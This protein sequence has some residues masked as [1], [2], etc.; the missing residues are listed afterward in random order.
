VT[1]G[2]RHV[3]AESR[4]AINPRLLVAAVIHSGVVWTQWGNWSRVAALGAVFLV[5]AVA[6]QVLARLSGRETPRVAFAKFLTNA[7]LVLLAGHLSAW[8]F[9]AYLYLTFHALA[10]DT[11]DFRA[12]RV[13]CVAILLATSVVA[14]SEHAHL[15]GLVICLLIALA[16]YASAEGRLR[17]TCRIL[18]EL[19]ERNAQL[20]DARLELEAMTARAIEQEKLSGLGMLA[21]GIAHEINNPMAFVTANIDLLLEDLRARASNDETLAEYVN[22]VLP[23]T[24]EGIDRVNVIVGDLR[25]FARG[26][27]EG[28][29]RYDLNDQVQAALRIMQTRIKHRC[30]LELDLAPL[31]RA[32]GLPQQL[33]QTIINL[34]ANAVDAH[35]ETS[36]GFVRVSTALA[37]DSILVRIADRGVGMSPGVRAQLFQ[38]FFTT[39]QVG[40]GTGLGL[41]VAY[42]IVKT[43]AGTIDVETELGEGSTFTV[44]LPVEPGLARLAAAA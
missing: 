9:P 41:S 34:L 16:T 14:L 15:P 39:K 20:T 32:T 35:P 43:H 1:P 30:E 3:A 12:L 44:R 38:P 42:G 33:V 24:L 5:Y 13:N 26:D 22:D 28:M 11:V 23:A 27:P 19:A 40:H 29:I 25:R 8:S 21:A 2:A 10:R 17:F 31:P 18:D 36:R 7:G 4:R 6:S 37:G